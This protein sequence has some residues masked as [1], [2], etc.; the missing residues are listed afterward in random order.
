MFTVRVD[1]FPNDIPW[2]GGLKDKA[3]LVKKDLFSGWRQAMD[4]N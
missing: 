3:Q 4:P 2:N 1:T